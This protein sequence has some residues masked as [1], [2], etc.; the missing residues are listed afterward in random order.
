M[1]TDAL[2]AAIRDFTLKPARWSV[3]DVAVTGSFD[4]EYT[5]TVSARDCADNFPFIKIYGGV[6]R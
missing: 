2:L 3:E 4:T 1:F 5:V 6:V